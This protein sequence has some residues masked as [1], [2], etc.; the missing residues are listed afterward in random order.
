M[1]KDKII[2]A[3]IQDLEDQERTLPLVLPRWVQ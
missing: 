1:D 3:L 2:D